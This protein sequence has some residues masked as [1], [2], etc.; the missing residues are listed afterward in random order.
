[1]KHLIRL[2]YCLLL[3]LDCSF[4]YGQVDDYN[5]KREIKGVQDQWHKI[6]LPNDIFG[7]T[8]PD[9]S[10]IRIFGLTERNDT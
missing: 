1:M 8:E 7:K 5:Y 10:D 3:L 4:S 9:F 6:I 2:S